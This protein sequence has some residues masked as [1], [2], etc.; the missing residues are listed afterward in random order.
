MISALCTQSFFEKNGHR[1]LIGNI[2]VKW[3]TNAISRWDFESV[4]KHTYLLNDSAL[5][6]PRTMYEQAP[7][8]P[9]MMPSS[10][11]CAETFSK[12]QKK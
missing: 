1:G 12:E 4:A 5:P 11:F 3:L 7:M 2:Y 9:G 6:L 8:D 10:P